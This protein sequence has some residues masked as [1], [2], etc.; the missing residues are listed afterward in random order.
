MHRFWFTVYIRISDEA[1]R[2]FANSHMILWRTLSS[3][4]ADVVINTWIDALGI[5][6][7]FVT[8]AV[9]VTSATNN[10]ASIPWIS[11]ITT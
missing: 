3:W 9:A 2:T 10:I 11:T 8:W 5:F 1:W 6:T 7:T 4:R